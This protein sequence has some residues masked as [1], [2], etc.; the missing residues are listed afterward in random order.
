MVAENSELTVQYVWNVL[1]S[2]SYRNWWVAFITTV[3]A[4]L[5]AYYYLLI[6]PLR[7]EIAENRSKSKQ[8]LDDAAGTFDLVSTGRS[9]SV[10]SQQNFESLRDSI[11]KYEASAARVIQSCNF[12]AMEQPKRAVRDCDA[13]ELLAEIHSNPNR[14]LSREELEAERESRREQLAQIL[15]TMRDA[16]EKFGDCSLD[17]IRNQLNMYL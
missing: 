1:S 11:G 15:S 16:P 7:K 2:S 10:S 14:F 9:E 17:D 5:G 12:T 4:L 3:F 8:E 13:R 6:K